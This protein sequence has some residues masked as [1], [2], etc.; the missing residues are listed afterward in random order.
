MYKIPRP[1]RDI[2]GNTYGN[3]TVLKMVQRPDLEANGQWWAVC[4]CHLCGRTDYIVK[5][6][7]IKS[8]NGSHTRSCGCDRTYF[9]KQTGRNSQL[10]RGYEEMSSAYISNTER[11][12]KKLGVKFNLTG[13]YLWDLYLKQNR[14]C[15]LSGVDIRFS[16]TNRRRTDGTAS[17]DRIDSNGGYVKG[18]VQWT[19]K[20]VNYMKMDL[21]PQELL[22]W[23]QKIVDTTTQPSNNTSV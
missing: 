15:A 10:F 1:I 8:P 20:T 5:P 3:L 16:P 11:R 19:H 21:S 18:N 12:A 22:D 23:C 4:K 14:K 9:K 2:T 6:Y 17:L 7:W 13:K